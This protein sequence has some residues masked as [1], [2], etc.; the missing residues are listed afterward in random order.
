MSK[1]EIS[2]YTVSLWASLPIP[3]YI[4]ADYN[5][6]EMFENAVKKRPH[7]GGDRRDEPANALVSQDGGPSPQKR[8]KMH[9]VHRSNRIEEKTTTTSLT[10]NSTSLTVDGK[11]IEAT[12]TAVQK[13]IDRERA[14]L[15]LNPRPWRFNPELYQAVSS[16]GALG[17][18]I[19]PET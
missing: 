2:A 11:S 16:G 7:D 5:V 10:V 19:R 8:Q 1:D 17:Q 9:E 6:K 14:R 3:T 18:I 4:D 15:T 12:S 13:Y